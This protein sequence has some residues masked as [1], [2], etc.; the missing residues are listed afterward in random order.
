LREYRQFGL[1]SGLQ[2]QSGW[3]LVPSQFLPEG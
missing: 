1:L 2:I 3:L